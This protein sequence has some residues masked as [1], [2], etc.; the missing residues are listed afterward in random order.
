LAGDDD[1]SVRFWGV[2]GSVATPGPDYVRYGGNTSCVEMRCAGRLLVF[3]AGT[4]LRP[5]SNSLKGV[6]AVDADLFFS[7]THFDHV[8]GLPFFSPLYNADDS[9]RFW[10]GHLTCQPGLSEVLK[11]MMQAPLFPVPFDIF[12]ARIDF[13]DFTA[14]ETLEPHPGVVVRTGALNHPNGATGYRVEHGGKSACYVT[15]TE[16]R[17]GE[18]DRD[19]LELIA[20]AD[21][22][23][24]DC[25]YTDAE[26]PSYA[27][28]GHSTWQEGARLCNAA[29]VGQ[30][31]IFHHDPSHDDRVMDEIAREAERVRPGTVVAREGM[32]LRP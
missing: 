4:G 28:W 22:L 16:H 11:L 29:G 26:Y 20:G 19:I 21:I 23:I 9:F 18:L 3:D 32:I 12:A 7:H 17:P 24:Y 1:L 14:G 13:N 10:S 27:G 15:D 25:T 5:L 31:A 2:R 8:V 6:G 30:L